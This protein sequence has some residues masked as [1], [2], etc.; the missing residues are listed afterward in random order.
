MEVF[1]H[2]DAFSPISTFY[3]RFHHITKAILALLWI[4]GCC[5]IIEDAGLDNGHSPSICL[6]LALALSP[7]HY[8]GKGKAEE[9]E[10]REK[11]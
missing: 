4:I 11:D 3:G 9:V 10:E 2:S 6:P 7:L 5:G 8:R 1:L